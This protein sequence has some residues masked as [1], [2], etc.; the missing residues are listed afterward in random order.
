LFID[1]GIVT[2]QPTA[3]TTINFD[4]DSAVFRNNIFAGDFT[5]TW[6]GTTYNNT[7]SLA[8]EDLN[9]RS[10]GTK[11][12]Y[13]NDSLNTCAILTDAWNVNR[14][15]WDFR[16]NTTGDGAIVTDPVNLNAG[17]DLAPGFVLTGSVLATNQTKGIGIF[18]IENGGGTSSGTI[19]LSIAK[20]ASFPITVPGLTLTAV[21]QSGTNGSNAEGAYTNGDWNFRDD[22]VNI[23]ATLKAGVVI[24][25]SGFVQLGF[26]V[27]RPISTPSGTNSSLSVSL[28]GGTDAVS[29]NNG[30]IQPVGAN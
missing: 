21:N 8:Y 1:N 25:K 10:R 14:A 18:I 29:A 17:V 13:A 23:I 24:P 9:S 22:G 30:A 19:V 15:L 28:L 2:G 20:P 4:E 5:T 11:I 3:P 7:K 16:P 12:E 26:N 27:T 6:T